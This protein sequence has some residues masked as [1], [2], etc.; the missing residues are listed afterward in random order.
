MFNN[1][2]KGGGENNK[3]RFE[4]VL[5]TIKHMIQEF[6]SKGRELPFETWDKW[7]QVDKNSDNINKKGAIQR[8]FLNKV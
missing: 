3:T 7:N 2:T 6:I 4:D 1:H 5:V 8:N